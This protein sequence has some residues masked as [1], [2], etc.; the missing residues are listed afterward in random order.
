MLG[1]IWAAW[2]LPMFWFPPIGLPTRTLTTVATWATSVV[3]WSVLLSYA[4]RRTNYS[5]PIAILLHAAL[6][7]GSAMGFAPL[8]ASSL[9]AEA[10]GSW[11]RLV[12][13]LVVLVAAVLLARERR[14]PATVPGG[15]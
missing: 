12:R 5:V 11:A 3:S 10:I 8:L 7:A 14:V 1:I 4:A 9:E 6:N 15:R 13:W 2:H